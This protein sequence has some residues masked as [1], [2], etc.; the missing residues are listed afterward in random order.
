MQV[1]TV[2]DGQLWVDGRMK[3]EHGRVGIFGDSAKN[4]V[5]R[6]TPHVRRIFSSLF[7]VAPNNDPFNHQAFEQEDGRQDAFKIDL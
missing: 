5:A 7:P 6:F 3:V 2:P 4:L 1:L